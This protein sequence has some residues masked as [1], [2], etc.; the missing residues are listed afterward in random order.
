MATNGYGSEHGEKQT[1][2]G[3]FEVDISYAGNGATDSEKYAVRPVPT[4]HVPEDRAS[5]EDVAP[6]NAATEEKSPIFAEI[7]QG[8]PLVLRALNHFAERNRKL[9]LLEAAETKAHGKRISQ[10]LGADKAGVIEDADFYADRLLVKART[11]FARA[12]NIG[13][14]EKI[15]EDSAEVSTAFACFYRMYGLREV[16]D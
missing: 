4:F 8:E 2:P 1:D 9:G 16:C 14:V 7:K 3:L 10:E 6:D 13:L 11:E 5:A 12:F 15:G